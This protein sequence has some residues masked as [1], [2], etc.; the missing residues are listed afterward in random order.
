M[1]L[2]SIALL[3]SLVLNTLLVWYARRL[4]KQF[5][6]FAEEIG[7]LEGALA[8]FDGH[9]RGIHELEMFYGD[10][11]LAGLIQHSREVVDRVKQFYDGFSLDE[12]VE[13]EVD[14]G[15]P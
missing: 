10:D 5:V 11:T 6:F 1:I 8:Q 14:N 7:D 4:T 15:S 2:I 13:E 12:D 9:L 3:F